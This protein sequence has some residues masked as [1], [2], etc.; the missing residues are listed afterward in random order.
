MQKLKRKFGDR[1]DGYRV[2]NVDPFFL[3]IPFLM[4]NRVD[5]Q[6]YFEDEIDITELEKFVRIHGDTDIPGLKMYHIFVA[7]CIRLYSQRPY[8]NR[9]CMRGRIYARKTMRVSMSMLRG[10]GEEGCVSTVIKPEFELSD[11]LADVVNRFN[12]IVE[13]NRKISTENNTDW[14]ASLIGHMPGFLARFVVNLLTFLDHH[15]RMPK[16]L[17]EVSPFH[18]SLFITNMGSIGVEPVF[19][20]IYEF[21]TTSLFIA[22]GK[23]K[24]VQ[25]IGPDGS[26]IKRRKMGVKVVADERIC[27]G[28]YYAASMRK[29]VKL[30]RNPE[31][32]LLPPEQVLIDDGIDMK[33]RLP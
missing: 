4:K 16:A 30:L 24:N 23:K 25:E 12:T 13:E 17:N 3:L 10:Q 31:R 18:T 19:H 26:V 33:G 20:H 21:G 29:L 8:L 2:K 22:I 32:L 15:G 5:S 1:Y 7:A 11:T 28:H 6:V 27:D 9:F 14:T